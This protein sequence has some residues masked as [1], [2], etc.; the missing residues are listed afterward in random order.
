MSTAKKAVLLCFTLMLPFV[1]VLG[2]RCSVPALN[3]DYINKTTYIGLVKIKKIVPGSAKNAS[4]FNGSYLVDIEEIQHFKGAVTKRMAVSGYHQTLTPGRSSSCDLNVQENQEWVVFGYVDSAGTPGLGMC[5]NSVI[6]RSETG[7]RDWTYKRGFNEL[8]ILYNHFN[9][10][11]AAQR[12][13]E[14]YPS[15]APEVIYRYKNTKKNGLTTYYYPNGDL[16]GK[17]NYK[18]DSLNGKSVWLNADGSIKS[19]STF[20]NGK[21]ID[22]SFFNTEKGG[23]FVVDIYDL[24]GNIKKSLLYQGFDKRYLYHETLFE[25]DKIK[26]TITR[27]ENEQI[28]TV[29]YIRGNGHTNYEE[30]FDSAGKLTRRRYWD[31]QGKLTRTENFQQ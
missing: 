4:S 29:A 12:E 2:C 24:K 10:H 30:E 9:I 25:N 13:N 5:T 11:R 20:K 21:K 15:G 6:Y 18:K 16:L 19:R 17:V 31:D 8:A 26:K 1:T 22:S 23:S 3:A 7:L 28:K 14:H 27:N